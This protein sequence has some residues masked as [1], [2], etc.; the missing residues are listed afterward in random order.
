MNDKRENKIK[1]IRAIV[2]KVITGEKAVCCA[3][4]I[5][6]LLITFF[7]VVM[8]FIFNSPFSWS[9]ELTL[10]FLVWFGYLCMPIHI[11]H[12]SHAALY[13]LYNRL[14]VALK[15]AVDIMRHGLLMWLFSQMIVYGYTITKLNMPKLQ[16]ATRVSQGWLFAPL[17]V[18]GVLMLIYCALNLLTTILKPLD[19]YRKEAET[20]WSIEQLNKE[21]GGTE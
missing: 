15:K 14:P 13:F 1:E 10:I 17:I 7:Q 16:P 9:E 21:R 2:E 6:M 8:R 12:D 4:L 18:G 5:I 3:L 11:F 20:E 19:A